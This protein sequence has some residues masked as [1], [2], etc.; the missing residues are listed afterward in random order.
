[1][2]EIKPAYDFPNEVRMLFAEYTQM[3]VRG[4]P[5]F[6][7]YLDLQHYDEEIERLQEKYGPPAGRLYLAFCEGEPAGCIGLR[8]LDAERCEMKRLYVRPRFRGRGIGGMLVQRIICDAKETGYKQMF[9]D[10]L[11]FLQS[12]LQLYKSCGFCETERYNDSPVDSSIFM[13][14]EL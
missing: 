14:L 11:P 9:L 2:T 12:A 6:G 8:Q 4:E 13:K 5:S 1:M 7:A 10:T 3:L